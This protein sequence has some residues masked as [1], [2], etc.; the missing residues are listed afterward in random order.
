MPAD[1]LPGCTTTAAA[2]VPAGVSQSTRVWP[3]LTDCTGQ[4]WPPTV[5]PGARPKLLPESVNR[6]PPPAG[7]RLGVSA[8]TVGEAQVMEAVT[9]AGA[10]GVVTRTTPTP[11]RL[12]G[13]RQ[14]STVF[15]V[16]VSG[17]ASPS[18]LTAGALPKFAPLSVSV[19]PPAVGRFPG[20]SAAMNGGS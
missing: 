5:T 6:V 13:T 17:H 8:E 10:L 14:R 2:P 7:P 9:P 4:G 19:T 3:P 16:N 18:R 11:P 15:E 20:V 1:T 12:A